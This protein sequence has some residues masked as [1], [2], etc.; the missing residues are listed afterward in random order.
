[1]KD[2]AEKLRE[3]C[4]EKIREL[5]GPGLISPEAAAPFLGTSYRTVYRWLSNDLFLPTMEECGWIINFTERVNDVGDSWASIVTDWARFS[6]AHKAVRAA[7]FRQPYLR[8]LDDDSLT[9]DEK[10]DRLTKRTLKE[11]SKSIGG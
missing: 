1:M 2:E 11:W 6:K 10:V 9:I 7:L 3:R 8:I 5:V 4:R